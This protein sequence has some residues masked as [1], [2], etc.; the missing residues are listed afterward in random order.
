MKHYQYICMIALAA[1]S[2]SL[3]SCDYSEGQLEPSNNLTSYQL[4]QGT[5][6]YDDSIQKF[7]N[8]YGVYLLY[9]FTEKYAYWTPSGWKK[10]EV[11]TDTTTGS[12][13][14]LVTKADQNYVK[15]QLSLLNEVWFSKLNDDAKKK[16]LPTMILLCAEVDQMQTKYIYSP[17]FK[18]IYVPKPVYAHYNY[19]NICVSYGSSAV[20]SVSDNDKKAF[21]KQLFEEWAQYISEHKATPS[22]EFTT[23]VNYSSSTITKPSKPLDCTAVGILNS[24][25]NVSASKDWLNFILMMLL[26]PESYL[27]ENPGNISNWTSWNTYDANWNAIYDYDTNFHGILNPAK[28]VNGILKER[29]QMVRQYFINN[30]NFDLQS[31]GNNQ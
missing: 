26:Y 10:G 13:G 20:T 16:L 19:D 12:D 2:V 31:I 5:H 1:A 3:T 23:S 30:F 25:Y 9:N 18:M 6:D 11:T 29:Y 8:N 24:G 17:N 15:Q 4:P 7:Y 28:D 21:R 14:F 22:D 27:T